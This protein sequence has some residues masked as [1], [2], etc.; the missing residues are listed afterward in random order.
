MQIN[1]MVASA[2]VALLPL[3]KPADSWA[4]LGCD[5]IKTVA[6]VLTIEPVVQMRNETMLA[7]GSGMKDS[8]FATLSSATSLM[9]IGKCL[10]TGLISADALMGLASGLSAAASIDRVVQT[11]VDMGVGIGQYSSATGGFVTLATLVSQ[12]QQDDMPG[13]L[14]SAARLIAL[15]DCEGN[16]IA[17]GMVTAASISYSAYCCYQTWCAAP[18]SPQTTH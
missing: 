7:I 17:M 15:I 16:S 8:V 4:D 1:N 9:S 12:M 14:L 11:A 18:S 3:V 6:D 2:P 10:R 13:A 5:W